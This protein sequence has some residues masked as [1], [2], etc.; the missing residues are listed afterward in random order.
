MVLTP[1]KQVHETL[2]VIEYMQ[3]IIE[4]AKDSTFYNEIVEALKEIEDVEIHKESRENVLSEL[5]INCN[6]V[7][8]QIFDTFLNLVK[9]NTHEIIDKIKD[10]FTDFQKFFE[11]FSIPLRFLS[12]K[13]TSFARTLPPF[14]IHF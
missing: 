5:I 7:P 1:T 14:L 11:L 4:Q 9:D 13:S 2:G 12:Y 3:E 10:S 6:F 8:A